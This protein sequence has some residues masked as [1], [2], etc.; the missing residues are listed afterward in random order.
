MRG[1]SRMLND[2][3]FLFAESYEGIIKEKRIILCSDTKKS[4]PNEY[5]RCIISLRCDFYSTKIE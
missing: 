4:C 2:T 5:D 1:N 3:K